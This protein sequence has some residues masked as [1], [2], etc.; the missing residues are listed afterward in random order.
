MNVVGQQDLK[1]G[2]RIEV[3]GVKL[4]FCLLSARK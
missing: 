2:D 4:T 1:E 3:A